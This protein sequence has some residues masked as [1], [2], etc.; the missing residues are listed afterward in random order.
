MLC[1]F[2]MQQPFRFLAWG[3]HIEPLHGPFAFEPREW[4]LLYFMPSVYAAVR[5][6]RSAT[7]L[8]T[9]G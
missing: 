2:F 1:G 9:S 5:F 3:L 7:S 6:C 4:G 8:E